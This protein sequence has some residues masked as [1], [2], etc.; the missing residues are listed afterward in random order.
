MLDEEAFIAI[1]VETTGLDYLDDKVI[2]VALANERNAWYIDF[3][4]LIENTKKQQPESGDLW[5]ENKI[6][7]WVWQSLHPLLDISRRVLIGHNSAFD[8]YFIRKELREYLGEDAVFAPCVNFWDTMQMAVL[9]DENLL[10]VSIALEDKEGIVRNVGA[11]SLKALA[12]IFLGRHP[13][14]WQENFREWSLD[15]RVDYACDDA[16]NTYDL[17]MLFSQ[18]LQDKELLDYYE[19]FVAP[20]VFVTEHL[21][22]NGIHV[23]VEALRATQAELNERIATLEAHIQA[24]VPS[25]VTY[26]Y[27]LRDPWSKAKFVAYAEAQQ[28]VLP[29]TA[30]GKPSV[31]A[32][33][34]EELS[35]QYP[36]EFNWDEVR[37]RIEEPFNVGSRQQLGR[38]LV[39]KGCRLPVTPSGQYSTS[40]DELKRAA[41]EWPELDIWAPLFEVQKLTKMRSVYVDG[42]LAVVWPEDNTVHPEW[43]S[44]GTTS[45]RYSCTA[46]DK[47]RELVHKRG[48][49]LQTI[50]NPERLQDEM[51]DFNPRSW[52]VARPG[53]VLLVGDLSQAEVRFLAVLSLC[54]VLRTSILRG[55]DLHAANAETLFGEEWVCAQDDHI[56]KVMRTQAKQGTFAVI[57]GAGPGTLAEQQDIAFSEAEDFLADF[58]RTFWGVSDWKRKMEKLILSKGYSTTYQG[59]RRTPV[60]IQAP[61]RVTARRDQDFELWKQQKLQEALWRSE[62]DVALRKGK[63]DPEHSTRH[64]REARAIR[65][66]INHAI[67]GSVGELINW[68]AWMLV[69]HGYTLRLQMHDELVVEVEDNPEAI[70][71]AKSFMEQLLNRS[72]DGIPFIFDIAVG[73]NWAAGKEG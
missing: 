19:K 40:E 47:N 33:V 59:R 11:L 27:G 51:W 63:L 69:Y 15:Q 7:G 23:D 8:L 6:I 68:A 36:G 34:L 46:S 42:V 66:C 55:G 67:Q 61:P 50:P 4:Q 65:Q 12:A 38:Y 37:V 16:R 62:L 26:K 53:H 30:S 5:H 49:A 54:P 56:R 70:A 52:Y 1:D 24:L 41:S 13:R 73:S 35:G 17:A 29:T 60:L 20:Q 18:R 25:T 43:N 64:E 14:L 28:W 21:E 44:T 31:T 48:P 45:G 10:G 57:Y 2:G 58:Y 9:H 71:A 72:I 3:P 32:K 22:R 39:S